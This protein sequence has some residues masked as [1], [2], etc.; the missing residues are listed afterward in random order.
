ML[1]KYL[2]V[3]SNR[4]NRFSQSLIAGQV[5]HIFLQSFRNGINLC[6]N[7][8]C[9]KIVL[10]APHGQFEGDDNQFSFVSTQLL[11]LSQTLSQNQLTT[12]FTLEVNHSEFWKNWKWH[13]EARLIL[14]LQIFRGEG[15]GGGGRGIHGWNIA[16][17]IGSY[18]IG[19]SRIL[20]TLMDISWHISFT[21]QQ[22]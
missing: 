7:K 11:T 6:Q 12:K 8:F 17:F 18:Q 16:S 15:G 21:F 5:R 9:L 22:K 3:A 10:Q 14:F 2:S 13:F 1:N 4:S 20:Y 19:V